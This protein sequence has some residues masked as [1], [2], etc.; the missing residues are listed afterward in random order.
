M[1]RFSLICA[2]YEEGKR[3]GRRLVSKKRIGAVRFWRSLSFAQRCY[4]IATVLL[5]LY[6][7][8]DINSSVFELTMFGFA[9][10]G[11]TNE[12]WPRF[13]TLWNSLPGKALILFVYAVIAN[14]ALAFASGLVN[15][16]T[17]VS[18]DALPYSHNFALILSLPTWFFATTIAALILVTLFMPAYL[19]IL[20]CLKPF[21]RERL[22]HAKHYRFVLSTALI[23]YIW[24]FAIAVQLVVLSSQIGFLDLFSS[25]EGT[26]LITV[27]RTWKGNS[28]RNDAPRESAN[29]DD[30]E[31]LEADLTALLDD[32]EQKSLR[33]SKAQRDLLAAFIYRFEAD[34]RSRCAHPE[35]TRVIELNDYEILQI[36]VSPESEN[37]YSYSVEPCR[38]AAIGGDENS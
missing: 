12:I 5:V 2:L 28:D 38:S 17:G 25:D 20:I 32:A 15:T 37:G 4:C 27:E 23:R 22:W 3:Y 26:P 7:F 34:S 18:A 33:F 11:I 30:N 1:E 19:F 35:Q 24:T 21:G 14:F 29:V 9:M 16:V 36:A 8:L 6:L 13:I 31:Q 10:A